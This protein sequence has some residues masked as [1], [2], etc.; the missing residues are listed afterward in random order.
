MYIYRER[1]RLCLYIYIYIY[2]HVDMNI[3][4]YNGHSLVCLYVDVFVCPF[5]PRWTRQDPTAP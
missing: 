3:H 1:E 2:T 5:K 4:K